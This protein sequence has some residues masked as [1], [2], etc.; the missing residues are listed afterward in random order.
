MEYVVT[1]EN[2]ALLQLLFTFCGDAVDTSTYMHEICI[3]I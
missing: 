1:H 2:K 3:H